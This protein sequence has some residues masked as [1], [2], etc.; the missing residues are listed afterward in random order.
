MHDRGQHPFAVVAAALEVGGDAPAQSGQR[1]AKLAAAVIFRRVLRRAIVGVVAILLAPARVFAGRL[2]M[3]VGV[4]AEPGIDIGRRQCQ[5]VEAIDLGA[6][7]DALVAVEIGPGAALAFAAVARF[8]VIAMA[9][10]RIVDP[11]VAVEVEGAS[12]VYGSAADTNGGTMP[13]ISDARVLIMATNRFEESELFGPRE[14]L[15]GQGDSVQAVD[16]DAIC[17]AFVVLVVIGPA[18][19]LAPTGVAGLAIAAVP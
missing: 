5:R 7:G 18:A 1:L 12:R 2:D 3:A 17:D 14:I 10:H 11:F 16:F 6:V 13:K 19:P 8:A 9:Q 4:L 15:Q